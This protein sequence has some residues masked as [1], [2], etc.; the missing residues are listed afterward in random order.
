[1]QHAEIYFS[2][3]LSCLSSLI[4][5]FQPH[6]LKNLSYKA[7]PVFNSKKKKKAQYKQNKTKRRR[8][9]PQFYLGIQTINEIVSLL[10]PPSSS[11]RH[12]YIE[13]YL[14]ILFSKMGRAINMSL[15]I[16]VLLRASVSFPIKNILYISICKST[17]SLVM[18]DQELDGHWSETLLGQGPSWMVGAVHKWSLGSTGFSTLCAF[19]ASAIYSWTTGD[20]R[21]G[22]WKY[23]FSV[24]ERT[25]L[26]KHVQS[27]H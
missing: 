13:L 17:G 11:C 4:F 18:W 3:L 5:Y 15:I 7:T 16:D 12:F 2:L 1:M 24:L 9:H 26:R 22:P 6:L 10:P 14:F 27:H 25:I 19:P 8:K 20:G 21:K 23:E